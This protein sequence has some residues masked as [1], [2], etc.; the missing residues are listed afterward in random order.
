MEHLITPNKDSQI[1]IDVTPASAGWQYLSFRVVA[2]SAGEMYTQAT[3]GN[4][5]A[6]VPLRGTAVLSAG[7]N[8]FSVSRRG[9]FQEPPHI[10]YAPPDTA[11]SVRATT[12]FEFAIGGAPAT[13][14]YPI[15]LFTPDEMKMEIR[16]GGAARRQVNHVL[17]HPLPAERLI[18]FE[19][20][21]PG[22][23][24]SGWP[25]H[26][27]DGYAGS[28]YLEEVYYYRIEPEA[29]YCIHRN[30]RRDIPFDEL[31][32]VRD[33]DLVLVTQGFH[34][35]A[36]PP[37]SQVYFLNYLAGE[38]LDEARGTPP[39]D[40]PDWGWMKEDYEGN[41]LKLPVFGND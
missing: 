27:H 20:Y 37:G 25:P 35:V 19:V 18:L 28:P 24:Y 38:L 34:P 6:V 11:V 15:R 10:L 33:G 4:E 21:V 12:S 32:T 7:G 31:F 41:M 26:C 13:G 36:V 5:V 30:Y 22:G 23:M 17:A 8:S 1:L 2:L 40:D 14:K 16:G 29:G 39:Y 9:Y 3:E